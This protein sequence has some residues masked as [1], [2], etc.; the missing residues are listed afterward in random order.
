MKKGV[1]M[2]KLDVLE[3][4]RPTEVIRCPARLLKGSNVN[5]DYFI[6]SSS[7]VNMPF[8]LP[9]KYTFV[10]VKKNNI[11]LIS[12]DCKTI[13]TNDINGMKAFR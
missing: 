1:I 10:L 8:Y 2:E 13:V 7:P 11:R 5:T 12:S 3:I 4:S 9:Q 6:F